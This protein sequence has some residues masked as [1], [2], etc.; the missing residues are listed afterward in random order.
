MRSLSPGLM[1]KINAVGAPADQAIGLP[2]T[3]TPAQIQALA[4]LAM[5]ALGLALLLYLRRGR[6]GR[7]VGAAG[8]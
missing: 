8:A 7:R 3:A 6:R 2:Q 4:G 1:R 5:L